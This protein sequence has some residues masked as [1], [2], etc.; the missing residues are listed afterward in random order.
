MAGRFTMNPPQ[1]TTA[2]GDLATTWPRIATM[3]IVQPVEMVTHELTEPRQLATQYRLF[4]RRGRA[5]VARDHAEMRPDENLDVCPG[6]VPFEY[7]S[8]CC[9]SFPPVS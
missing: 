7:S 9:G 8:L 2:V 1:S 5:L 6:K 4:R 3:N